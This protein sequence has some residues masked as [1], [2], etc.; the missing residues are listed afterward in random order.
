MWWIRLH[1]G[2]I[3]E[4]GLL[5]LELSSDLLEITNVVCMLLIGCSL[6]TPLIWNDM[7]WYDNEKATLD[8]N[9]PFSCVWYRPIWFPFQEFAITVYY[10]IL[11]YLHIIIVVLSLQAWQSGQ[12]RLPVRSCWGGATLMQAKWIKLNLYHKKWLP[13][14]LFYVLLHRFTYN[15]RFNHLWLSFII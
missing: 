10:T 11:H 3:S 2:K 15:F 13:N 4:W 12:D 5:I 6:S 1:F 8:T 14:I 7:I 9:M